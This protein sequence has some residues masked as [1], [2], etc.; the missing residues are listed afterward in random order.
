MS[1]D[2]IFIESI[3]NNYLPWGTIKN[4][5][6]ENIIKLEIGNCFILSMNIGHLSIPK[7]TSYYPENYT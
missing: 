7:I 5:M 3:F 1:I 2:I 6:R 4:M